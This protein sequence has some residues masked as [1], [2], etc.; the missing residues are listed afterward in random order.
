MH[1]WVVA[2]EEGEVVGH[3]AA[4][5]Q[6]YRI[7]HQRVVAHTPADY[8]VLPGYGFHAITLMRKFFRTC[9]NCVA[10]DAAPAAIGVET[11]L[12]AEESGGLQH[13]AKPLKYSP[14]G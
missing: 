1:R 13:A 3:L 8:M 11:G 2:T 5:P 14:H 6:F 9:E 7:S 12:G 4:Q 10:C